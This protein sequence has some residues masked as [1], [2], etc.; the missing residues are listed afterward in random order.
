MMEIRKATQRGHADHGWLDSHHSF[1]FAGY[2]D[3]RFMGFGD[4]R[5]INEDRVAPGRGFGT[6]PHRDMEIVSYVVDGALS[7]RDTI[8]N[9]SVI[10]PGEV[11]LMSAGRGI[12]HSE[13]NHDPAA[14]VHF[15]Q[16]WLL[17]AATGTAPRYEQRFFDPAEGGVRLVASPDG[18][19]GSLT[20]G[21]D[22]DLYRVLL[23]AGE[24]AARPLRRRRA[25]VQVV[26]G[27]LEVEGALLQPGDGL[28]IDARADETPPTL[29]LTA[30]DDVEALLFDLRG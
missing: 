7:H 15:L 25:W 9:G 28:A 30:H 13:M 12:A 21:Q 22:V 24:T 27:T 16:I 6:H 14:P 1:S 17:P 5:V 2:Y 19:D 29:R 10:R 26:R 23:G 8:G 20:I 4:L 18:R 3:P 11:Q